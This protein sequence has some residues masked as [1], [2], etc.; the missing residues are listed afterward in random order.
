MVL[1]TVDTIVLFNFVFC[2]SSATYLK[3]L[4]CHP[5]CMVGADFALTAVRHVHFTFPPA[6]RGE[7]AHAFALSY[8]H[9]FSCY[10]PSGVSD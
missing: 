8:N 3:Y 9:G 2:I 6:V 7:S 5:M 10:L 4:V 1:L